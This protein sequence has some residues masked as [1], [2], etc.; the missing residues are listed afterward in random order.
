MSLIAIAGIRGSYSEE[1][2]TKMLGENTR[3]LEC[4]DFT[5]T[6]RAVSNGEAR[7]AVVPLENKIVGEIKSAT[8]ALK[9]TNLRIFERFALEINHVLIGTPAADFAKLKS[10]ASHAE[11]LKQCRKFLS[12]TIDLEPVAGGDTASCVK[13]II[14]ENDSSR[15]AIG[16]PRA[17]DIYGGKILKE[18]IADAVENVTTFYLVGN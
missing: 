16:S 14:E 18:N 1:A 11:A 7:F 13:K 5:Q 9:K 2:A 4:A 10:V 12:G 6:F 3:I 17:A 15:A 8:E